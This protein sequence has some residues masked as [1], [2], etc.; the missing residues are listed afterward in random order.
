MLHLLVTVLQRHLTV[1]GIKQSFPAI[2]FCQITGGDV[3]S[4]GKVHCFQ[5]LVRDLANVNASKFKV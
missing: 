1:I 5:H 4:L 3:K 2:N